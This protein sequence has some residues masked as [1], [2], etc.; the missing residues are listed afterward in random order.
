MLEI[1]FVSLL[2]ILSVVI[3]ALSVARLDYG[4]KF[5]KTAEIDAILERR[6]APVINHKLRS[7]NPYAEGTSIDT[8]DSE[9][10]IMGMYND[11]ATHLAYKNYEV[12]G[13][14]IDHDSETFKKAMSSDVSYD[15]KINP[16]VP[17]RKVED[18]GSIGTN[19]KPSKIK[20]TAII[21]LDHSVPSSASSPKDLSEYTSFIDLDELQKARDSQMTSLS[22]YNNTIRGKESGKMLDQLK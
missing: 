15:Q 19:Y 16:D 6:G 14:M 2:S 10:A 3:A 5:N 12:V 7:S 1:I 20:S 11:N 13:S 22:K 8:R 17:S 21:D 18:C 4:H 9:D